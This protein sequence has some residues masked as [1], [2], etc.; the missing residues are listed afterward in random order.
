MPGPTLYWCAAVAPPPR[1]GSSTPQSPAIQ[2]CC[3]GRA[4]LQLHR[5]C[6]TGE[7][8]TIRGTTGGRGRPTRQSNSV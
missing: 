7:N 6:F 5:M 4:P 1:A 2:S 3:R 8:S